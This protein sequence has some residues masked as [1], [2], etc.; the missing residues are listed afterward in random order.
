VVSN[1]LIVSAIWYLL[2]LWTGTAADLEKMQSLVVAFV[3]AG[4]KTTARHRVD[5]ATICLPKCQGGLGL[6]SIPAQT[7][8]LSGK[9][10]L[11]SLHEK[12]RGNILQDLL[13]YYVRQKSKAAWGLDDFT[14]IFHKTRS[15]FQIG[16]NAFRTMCKGW[17]LSKS[18]IIPKRPFNTAEWKS[19]SLWRPHWIHFCA[20]DVNCT[21]NPRRLLYQAGIATFG[22]IVKQDGSLKEWSEGPASVAP[23]RCS[24]PKRR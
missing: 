17:A 1:H 13:Q 9:I 11:W 12:Q 23:A 3:W 24:E 5:K 4:K 16:S 8:S 7:E 22:D 18:N 19:I 14:W 2:T 21:M 10:L 6:L 15:K 20:K